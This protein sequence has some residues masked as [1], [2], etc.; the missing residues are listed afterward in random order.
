MPCYRE[1]SYGPSLIFYTQ[2]DVSLAKPV[3]QKVQDNFETKYKREV[4]TM[5]N[6]LDGLRNKLSF[7]QG[8]LENLGQ[9]LSKGMQEFRDSYGRLSG[10]YSNVSSQVGRVMEDVTGLT[11]FREKAAQDVEQLRSRN[12][13]L[14][15]GLSQLS[16]KVEVIRKDVNILQ[17][18]TKSIENDVTGLKDFRTKATK[19]IESLD[20]FKAK[21]GKDIAELQAFKSAEEKRQAQEVMYYKNQIEET[22]ATFGNIRT[23]V[24]QKWFGNT[25]CKKVDE[26]IREAI[27]SLRNGHLPDVAVR[28]N[29]AYQVMET[30]PQE[31]YKKESEYMQLKEKVRIF[32]KSVH[33]NGCKYLNAKQLDPRN[34]ASPVLIE[35]ELVSGKKIKIQ[36]FLEGKMDVAIEGVRS[37]REAHSVGDVI[38]NILGKEGLI[39]AQKHTHVHP[40][41]TTES[42]PEGKGREKRGRS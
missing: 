36:M 12:E 29:A 27:S 9:S 11:M 4:I 10:Q 33:Q 40:H 42:Q 25:D 38:E 22:L 20:D 21:A 30:L 32:C 28:V 39:V 34:P 13:S 15:A 35:G 37:E 18:K 17:D 6:E 23:A 3:Y 1:V 26:L 14:A 41:K 7:M 16:S 5:Q 31:A 2:R 24:V 8:N 19:Q